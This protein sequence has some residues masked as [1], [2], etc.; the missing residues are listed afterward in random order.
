MCASAVPRSLLGPVKRVA[1]GCRMRRDGRNTLADV[2]S[3]HGMVPRRVRVALL[4]NA[5]FPFPEGH[6]S[7]GKGF[8]LQSGGRTD[9]G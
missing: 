3:R 7:D 1:A 8:P 4:Y 9:F 2:P 6:V 5:L